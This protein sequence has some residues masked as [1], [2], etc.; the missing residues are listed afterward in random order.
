MFCSNQRFRP[1]PVTLFPPGAPAKTFSLN[2]EVGDQSRAYAPSF[3]TYLNPELNARILKG[4]EKYIESGGGSG[5]GLAI[6]PYIPKNL[7]RKDVEYQ[8]TNQERV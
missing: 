7:Q 3:I 4:Y 5:A 6:R 2:G 8:I 1:I